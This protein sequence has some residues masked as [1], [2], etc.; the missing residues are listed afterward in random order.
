MLFERLSSFGVQQLHV[1]NDPASGLRGFVAL[2]NINAGAA[3]GGCRAIRYKSE[4][5]AI[6][7]VLRLAEG[8]ALK[9]A[10][11]NL[12][13]GGGK[14]VIMLPEGEVDREAVFAAWGRFVDSFRGDYITA[15]DSGTSTSDMDVVSRH[16]KYVLGTSGGSGD[17]S[18]YT[19]RG[20]SRGIEVAAAFHLMRAD[21]DGLHVAIQGLGNV[22]MNLARNLHA[23]GCK[24]TVADIVPERVEE[25]ADKFDATPAAIGE[26][27]FTDCDVVSPCALG[28]SINSETIPKLR[29]KIVAG[30]ANNQLG[31]SADGS[32]LFELGILYAPDYAINAGGLIQVA[33]NWIGNTDVDDVYNQVDA[34]GDT[35][36]EIWEQAKEVGKAPH[37]VADDIARARIAAA[38]ED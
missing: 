26:V 16:T 22:G 37:L 12:P 7:D 5:A 15:E 14:G 3:I 35:L 13:H 38:G 24:L 23:L 4:D 32:S 20:V 27:L 33:N 2:H 9:S 17:P 28:Q 31:S 8:M 18:P 19:A 36:I 25:A 34:I 6:E 11:S 30:S 29:A 10:I 21:L 1:I